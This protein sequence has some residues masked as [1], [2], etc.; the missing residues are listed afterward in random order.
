MAGGAVSGGVFGVGVRVS[1]SGAGVFGGDGGSV[2]GVD[3]AGRR[4]RRRFALFAALA[5]LWRRRRA[6]HRPQVPFENPVK[7]GNLLTLSPYECSFPNEY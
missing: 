5:D 3:G 7:L 2:F 1:A 4:R 6:H